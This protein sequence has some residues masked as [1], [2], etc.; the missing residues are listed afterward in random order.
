M[1]HWILVL[2]LLVPLKTNGAYID[3]R[4]LTP[5]IKKVQRLIGSKSSMGNAHSA[6]A[7]SATVL[8]LGVGLAIAE[9]FSPSYDVYY[10][11]HYRRRPYHRPYRSYYTVHKRSSIGGALLAA[12]VAAAA[13]STAQAHNIQQENSSIEKQIVTIIDNLVQTDQDYIKEFKELSIELS[14]KAIVM[15]QSLD[16]QTQEKLN[17]INAPSNQMESTFYTMAKK[18]EATYNLTK[19]EKTLQSLSNQFLGL[20][21]TTKS[22]RELRNEIKF[23]SKAYKKAVKALKKENK[24]LIKKAA[25]KRKFYTK[26][27]S[28]QLKL[29]LQNHQTEYD[30]IVENLSAEIKTLFQ[31]YYSLYHMKVM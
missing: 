12:G 7:I 25:K 14:N 11:S 8:S 31:R 16:Q 15:I 22:K 29:V 13:A 10:S 30:R 20:D 4:D 26:T 3:T 9:A 5:E 2:F 23:L 19:Y 17:T 24:L 21:Q 27:L 28:K 6:Q 1:K 18:I